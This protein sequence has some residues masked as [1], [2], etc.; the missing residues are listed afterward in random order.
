MNSSADVRVKAEQARHALLAMLPPPKQQQRSQPAA[1]R[2][3][4]TPASYESHLA[5]S[6]SANL[7]LSPIVVHPLFGRAKDA[8]GARRVDLVD[9]FVSETDSR[10]AE[11][12]ARWTKYFASPQESRNT[13]HERWASLAFPTPRTEAVRQLI[14]TEEL[15]E[16]EVAVLRELNS[17]KESESVKDLVK[18]DYRTL[19]PGTW[20]NDEIINCFAKLVEKRADSP[21][22]PYVFSSFMY[23]TLIGLSGREYQ[24]EQVKKW[25]ARGPGK[26]DLFARSAAF[27][28]INLS[29]THWCMAVADMGA[30]TLTYYDSMAGAGTQCLQT[31]LRYLQDEHQDKKGAP[32]P[33]GWMAVSAR[34]STP[35][36]RNG[37]DCGVFSVTTLNLLA[38]A[39]ERGIQPNLA[40]SFGQRD[41]PKIR[42]QIQLDLHRGCVFP[43]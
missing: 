15:T 25:T 29:N 17:G 21:S 1:A 22:R 37:V 8:L 4:A 23:S 39:F 12:A 34:D 2:P 6:F 20:L 3:S 9:E 10:R 41:I 14:R 13:H 18:K 31:L 36:Q 33:A 27:F 16:D 24:Y 42:Q 11:Q 28:P 7:T 19:N 35:Q 30:K 40:D 32:L 43:L 38:F 5:S 26:A